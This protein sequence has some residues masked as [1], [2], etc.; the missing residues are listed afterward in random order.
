[1]SDTEDVDSGAIEPADPGPSPAGGDSWKRENLNK[2][3]GKFGFERGLNNMNNL[4]KIETISKYTIIMNL[5]KFFVLYK[6]NSTLK[7]ASDLENYV[8]PTS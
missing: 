3:S 8:K 2:F 4:W 6:L 5:L 7:K 1:M